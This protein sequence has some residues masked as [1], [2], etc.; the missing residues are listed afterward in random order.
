MRAYTTKSG[1][2]FYKAPE[3]SLKDMDDNCEGW[4]LVCGETVPGCEADAVQY[5][6][7]CCGENKVFGPFTL[8]LRNLT[9]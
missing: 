4:C 5:H 3:A 9:Y 8:A 1:R 6:C 2:T 7:D